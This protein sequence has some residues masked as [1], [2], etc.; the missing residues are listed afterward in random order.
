M[1]LSENK[2]NW[3]PKPQ[4]DANHYVI[5]KN[6]NWLMHIQQNGELS[7]SEQNHNMLLISKSPE[8]FELLKECLEHHQGFHSEIGNKIRTM[9]KSIENGI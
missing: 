7:V 2:S 5:L 6:G 4:G 3:I 1:E 9:I 8:M